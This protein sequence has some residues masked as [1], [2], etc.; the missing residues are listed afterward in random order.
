[1]KGYILIDIY[2][3][4]VIIECI[5][6][7]KDSVLHVPKQP[8]A[9]TFVLPAVRYYEHAYVNSSAEESSDSEDLDDPDIESVQLDENSVH[10]YAYANPKKRP[11]WANTTLRDARDHFGNPTDTRR[12]RYDFEEPPLAL[13]TTKAMPPKYIFLVQSSYPQSYGEATRN[14][15]LESTMQED[16]NSLLEN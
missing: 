14:S 10:P 13:T 1:V 8:H 3:Y 11:K 15:F 4:R 7:F 16:Y 12:T 2:S 6:Q 5:F 9:D